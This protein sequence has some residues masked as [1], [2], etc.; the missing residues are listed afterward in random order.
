MAATPTRT[1]TQVFDRLSRVYDN[2][3]VQTLVYRPTQDRVI[4]DLRSLAPARVLDVGCGTGQLTAR[5][6]ASLQPGVVYGCDPSSGMLAKARARSSSVTWLEGKAEAVPLPDSS[7]DA[8]IS[9]EAFHFFDQPAAVAE[10]HRLLAPGGHA[11]VGLL[12]P[13][14]HVGSLVLD[15]PGAGHWPTRREMRQLFEDAGFE[16]V[17]QTHVQ[18]L[19]GRLTPTYVTVAARLNK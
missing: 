8:V 9:T 10:F 2:Q 19:V 1:V 5:I 7:V 3:V 6:Q 18:R 14:T 15:L 4:E 12:N 16:I 13:T 11:V 17:R